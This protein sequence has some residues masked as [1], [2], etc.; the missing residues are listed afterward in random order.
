MRQQ[1]ID[2][3]IKAE[4]TCIRIETDLRKSFEKHGRGFSDGVRK[5][6]RRYFHLL[7]DARKTLRWL[8]RSKEKK[9]EF[10][11]WYRKGG[12]QAVREHAVMLND[13]QKTALVDCI[14]RFCAA[15]ARGEK[16]KIGDLL[17]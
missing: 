15:Q 2:A 7:E 13:L 8:F 16:V 10:V 4:H 1:P 6:G 14:E 12:E 17:K 5:V 11:R 9:W 3:P